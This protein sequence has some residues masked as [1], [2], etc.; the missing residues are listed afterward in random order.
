MAEAVVNAM[1]LSR[2][3]AVVRLATL[4]GTAIVGPDVQPRDRG[5]ARRHVR[6]KA[7]FV[8]G[9]VASIPLPLL[10]T[11]RRAFD[12]DRSRQGLRAC[13][14]RSNRWCSTG[15]AAA[16]LDAGGTVLFSG[17][18][19][20]TAPGYELDLPLER[21]SPDEQLLRIEAA[22]GGEKVTR[23]VRFTIR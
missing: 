15:L 1:R 20:A 19:A 16:I 2:R 12:P 13:L 11:A 4:M 7:A 3:E 14:S 18:L 17:D 23:S 21:L 8:T 5:A 10:A 22:S 9:P 6:S